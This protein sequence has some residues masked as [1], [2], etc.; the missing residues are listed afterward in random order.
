[1]SFRT[2]PSSNLNIC[3]IIPVKDEEDTIIQCLEALRLQK[4][5]DN[6]PLNL[7]LFE[8]LILANNCL[9]HTYSHIKEYQST[10]PEFHL[11][12]EEVTFPKEDANIGTARRFLMDIAYSR[13]ALLNRNGIIASTDGDT[14][15]DEHWINE[16]EIEMK[17]GCDVVGGEIITNLEDSIT[18]QY[19]LN[20]IK[21][22]NLIVR[23]ESLIDPK[24]WN[25]WPSHFQCFGANFAIKCHMYEKAGRLPR[26]SCLEDVAFLKS[27]ELK[28]AKIR[29][30]PNVKVI[31]SARKIGRVEKG[32]SQQL[33][34]FEYLGSMQLIQSVECAESIISRIEIKKL[35][36]NY[37]KGQKSNYLHTLNALRYHFEEEILKKWMD[38]SEY[39]GELWDKAEEELE[40]KK[41][42][43][44]WEPVDI[45][46]ALKDLTSYVANIE[47]PIHSKSS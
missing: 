8:V 14:Q 5:R 15:V 17:K 2:K 20:D 45:E 4:N 30:S 46:K 31:T 11:L 12:V 40:R 29:R 23:L 44:Q 35:L 22:Q 19:H 3:V 16:I 38:D 37:W 13:F 27:L 33:A 10:Y 21:Y 25:P 7:N 28:D 18:R 24:P 26:V 32:L 42:F 36:F 9:D 34:W 41:W 47:M 6:S 43:Q 39:F 1:M